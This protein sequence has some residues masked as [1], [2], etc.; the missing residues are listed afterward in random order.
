M[1]AS[2]G[3]GTPKAELNDQ[4]DTMSYAIGMAQSQGLKEYLVRRLGVDTAYMDEFIKGLNDGVNAGDDKKKT[5]YFAGIQIGQQVSQQIIKGINYEIFGEDS[6]QTISQHNFMAGFISGTTEQSKLMEPE[7]AQD[8][9]MKLMQD[10]KKQQMEKQFGEWKAENQQYLDSIAKK[11]GVKKLSDGVYYEVIEEGTGE[12]PVDTSNVSVHYEGRLIND[13]IFDS[14]YKRKEP[15]TLRVNQVIQGW[16]EAL[17]HMPVGSTWKVYIGSEKG[18]GERAAGEIKPFST[19]IF[20]LELKEI[21][22]KQQ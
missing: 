14:S 13:T 11:E 10:V 20:K 3:N 6:T 21:V 22:Y 1:L 8:V 15:T 4:V 7:E 9:A 19:L 12:V 17:T 5:A 2:C 16:T 18:Y